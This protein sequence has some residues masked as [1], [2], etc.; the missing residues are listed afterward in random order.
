LNVLDAI[1]DEDEGFEN[2]LAV[3]S[4][5][6]NFLWDAPSMQV[7]NKVQNFVA[8]IDSFSDDDFQKHMRLKKST[9][10]F[11]IC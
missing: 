8:V 2:L 10:E 4:L 3:S 1:E 9:A 6:H 11:L 5:L 7:H